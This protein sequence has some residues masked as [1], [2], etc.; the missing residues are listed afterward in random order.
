MMHTLFP[1]IRNYGKTF[2]LSIYI[3]MNPTSEIINGGKTSE[4]Q[5][6]IYKKFIIT[7]KGE[8]MSKKDV[9]SDYLYAG[10]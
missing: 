7:W 6:D 1:I 4:Y 9:K 8:I 10:K 5:I 2:R 3:H